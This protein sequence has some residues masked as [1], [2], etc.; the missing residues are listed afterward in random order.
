MTFKGVA[1]VDESWSYNATGLTEEAQIVAA[2]TVAYFTA[3]V[4]GAIL[5]QGASAI[6][7]GAANSVVTSAAII[8]ANQAAKTTLQGKNF[9]DFSHK[10]FTSENTNRIVNA[11]IT[12]GITGALVVL[13]KK[14]NGQ[15]IWVVILAKEC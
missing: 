4:G 7:L 15:I 6:A 2:A 14:Q 13:C 5:G 12:G 10:T 3:G 11:G 1:D 8:A 9:K